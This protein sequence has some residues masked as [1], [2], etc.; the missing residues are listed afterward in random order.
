MTRPPDVPPDTVARIRTGD[1]TAF[2]GMFRAHYAELCAFAYRYINDS[3]RAEELVQ[4]LF[5]DL[6]ARRTQ[7]SVHGGLR[8]YLYAATRNRCLNARQRQLLERNWIESEHTA[9]LHLL[10]SGQSSD[11]DR[12]VMEETETRV[13][14]AIDALP[15]RCRLIMELRWYRGLNYAEIAQAMSISVKGVENQ[16]ARGLKSLR[17]RLR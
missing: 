6:W 3:D 1:A 4:D 5:A 12:L 10:H 13:R 7:W 8:A 15:E 9:D 14:R 17:E 16:L 2:E 11:S